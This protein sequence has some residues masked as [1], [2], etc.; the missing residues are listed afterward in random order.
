MQIAFRM[1]VHSGDIVAE[2]RDIY[3]AG[4]NLAARLEQEAAPGN[5]LISGAVYEQLGNNLKLPTRDLGFK[6]F[7]NIAKRVRVFEIT[8]VPNSN[9][10]AARAASALP[11]SRPSIAVLPFLE[12]DAAADR[13]Y[14]GDGLARMLLGLSPPCLIFSSFREVRP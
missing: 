13:G 14:L 4:V 8:L 12:Y 5:I 11:H 3:G 2:Q 6:H 7:K 10:P 9:P 1:G